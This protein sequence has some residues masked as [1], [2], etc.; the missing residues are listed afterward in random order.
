MGLAR[1]GSDRDG[2]ELCCSFASEHHT[3]QNSTHYTAESE[4]AGAVPSVPGGTEQTPRTLASTAHEHRRP[5]NTCS[6]SSEALAAAAGLGKPRAISHA[7]GP[8]GER[9]AGDEERDR[10][11]DCGDAGLFSPTRQTTAR[12]CPVQAPER[13]LISG[14]TRSLLGAGTFWAGVPAPLSPARQALTPSRCLLRELGEAQKRFLQDPTR[15]DP[16]LNHRG[17]FHKRKCFFSGSPLSF[18]KS[19]LIAREGK[20]TRGEESVTF[21]SGGDEPSLYPGQGTR[22]FSSLWFALPRSPLPA[23]PRPHANPPPTE[24]GAGSAPCGMQSSIHARR[25]RTGG[26]ASPIFLTAAAFSGVFS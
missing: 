21:G 9:H 11:R 24:E 5:Q 15:S 10:L 13:G 14:G 17:L 16:S 26:K 7:A 4:N 2:P 20:M 6:A 22:V 8:G 3:L 19:D 18:L 23:A 25:R 12:L 1:F